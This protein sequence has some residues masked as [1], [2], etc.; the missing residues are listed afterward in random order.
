M[1]SRFSDR[2]AAEF[3]ERLGPRWGEDLAL[4]VYTSRLIGRDTSLV[5]HGGGNTSL[6]GVVT[7][8]LGDKVEALFIKGSGWDLDSIEPPGLPPVRLADLRRLR[9][10]PALSDEEMVNQLRVSLF[11]AGAP[12]PSVETLLHAF[13]PHRYID[14]SHA[15]IALVVT[16]QPPGDA[17][18][19]A[20]EAFGP[21][22]AIV[23]YVMP[24]F[25]LAKLAA[26]VYERDPSVEGLVLL[27]HGLFTF[28]DDART[29]YERMIEA[30]DRA[31]RFV[32][33]RL[34]G[35]PRVVV[36]GADL[37]GAARAAA[38]LAPALRGALAEQGDG[39]GAGFQRMLLE[40]RAS[41]DV[42]EALARPDAAD[43][44]S[45]GPLTPD[46]V[47]RTKGPALFL[48]GALPLDDEAAL[49]DRL[50]EAVAAYRAHYDR[51]F[52][53]NKGRARGSIKKLDASPRVVLAPGIGVLAAGR[54]KVAARIAADIAEHTVS[55]KA[56]ANAMGRYTALPGGDLFDVEYW[57]LEQA[58]LGKA[59]EPALAGQVALVTGAAGA[60]GFGIAKQLILAGAHVLVSDIEPARVEEARRE[61]DPKG[62]GSAAGL[63]MDVTDEASVAR[64][65]EEA[66]RLYGGLDILVLN[67]GIA[68]VSR[69]ESMD[70]AAL[71]KVADVN[72]I[73]VFLA[74]RE[75]ARIFRRQG[76]GGNVI[77]NAS[78]NVFAPGAEFAAYSATKAG[79][80]QLGKVAA[81]ELA[82][83]GVRVNMI[84]ADAVFGDEKRPSGLWQMVGPERARSR[85][86]DTSELKEYYRQ[87]NLLKASISAEHVGNAVVFFASNLTPTTGAT[88]PVDGGVPEAFPR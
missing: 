88:L 58:K 67:A 37:D 85:G 70:L 74:L 2:E 21:R 60:I 36:E 32:R 26:E 59:K 82:S 73:G 84:N 77:V 57:S 24:G 16:N 12:S 30:A 56:L 13:L 81:L 66:S 5:M 8:L 15:D 47:I 86:L 71:R 11:D 44:A 63:V 51:Y 68:H 61:L 29:A 27:N 54:T 52:E 9:A 72:L 40:H 65:F 49:R 28:A 76:T 50:K 43:L 75:G 23:P 14:H 1:E 35:A 39:E 7:T 79:A 48:E 87:R 45:R 17:E 64:G 42:L 22:F 4:R 78:K 80:H 46:H 34:A 10:L 20:R 62:K 25:A 69:I 33:A 41:G 53:E 55:A 6:K 83:I 3:I 31:E 19:L 18:A 38:K